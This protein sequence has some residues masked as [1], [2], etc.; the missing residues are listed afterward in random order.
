[1]NPSLDSLVN[2]FTDKIYNKRF[3]QR[4]KCKDCKKLKKCQD[5]SVEC[6]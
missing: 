5:K 3:K 2:N 1:M 6:C 4:M